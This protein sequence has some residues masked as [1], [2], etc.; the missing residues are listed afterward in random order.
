MAETS[1][2]I[3]LRLRV[4]GQFLVSDVNQNSYVH[5]F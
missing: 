5:E 2:E 1:A 3:H 4:K